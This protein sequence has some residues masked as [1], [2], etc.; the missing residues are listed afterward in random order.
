MK[1][2]QMHKHSPQV[3]EICGMGELGFEPAD[4]GKGVKHPLAPEAPEF[5]RG[6]AHRFLIGSLE[7]IN[8]RA[9]KSYRAFEENSHTYFSEVYAQNCA[10]RRILISGEVL[11]FKI[12]LRPCFYIPRTSTLSI[13][14]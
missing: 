1:W 4:E 8:V 13:R 11:P 7:S 9:G 6:V 3:N 10:I 14:L 5:S 2:I 12:F